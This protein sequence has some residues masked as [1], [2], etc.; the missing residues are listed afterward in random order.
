MVEI[1]PRN[2]FFRCYI[3][4]FCHI[5]EDFFRP[6]LFFYRY[7]FEWLIN[8]NEFATGRYFYFAENNIFS[9]FKS[10]LLFTIWDWCPCKILYCG[11]IWLWKV[12]VILTWKMDWKVSV[13]FRHIFRLWGA[14]H[15]RASNQLLHYQMTP[16]V[17]SQIL[18][19]GLCPTS[20][21]VLLNKRQAIIE[22]TLLWRYSETTRS[23]VE[24]LKV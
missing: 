7:F 12:W 10:L 14:L 9:I 4:K 19:A 3:G 1:W 20:L 22:L 17:C 16:L 24:S 23:G 6:V 15:W 13:D 11:M 5:F 21:Q 8:I 2:C 18:T